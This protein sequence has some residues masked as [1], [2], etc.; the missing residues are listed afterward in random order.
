MLSHFD[1]MVEI[2]KI[3]LQLMGELAR[4]EGAVKRG[5]VHVIRS[6]GLVGLYTGVTSCLARD[7]MRAFSFE[8]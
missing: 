4:K 6:L 8:L 5:A 3:R 7:G 2:I 1:R